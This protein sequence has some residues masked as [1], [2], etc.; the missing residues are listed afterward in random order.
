L[1]SGLISDKLTHSQV[2]NKL[3]DDDNNNNVP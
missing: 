3:D 2:Q 1:P